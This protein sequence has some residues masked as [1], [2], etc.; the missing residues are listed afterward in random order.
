MNTITSTL[1][2]QTGIATNP[3]ETPQIGAEFNNFLQLLTAQLRNQDPLSPADSTQFVEQLATFSSLEQQVKSNTSLETIATMMGDLHAIVASEWLG[4]SVSV[5]SAWV[6]F[7]GKPVEFT[8]DIPQDVDN[9]IL[10]IRDNAGA[11]VWSS[12]LDPSAISHSW[13]GRN[14]RNDAQPQGV[15]QFGVDL[16]RGDAFAGTLAPRIITTVTDIANENG[17]LKFGT[18]SNLTTDLENVRKVEE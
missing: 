6:P 17:V 11:E 13:S 15:Y 5:E 7:D 3:T 18:A 1:P 16:Y 8:A 14:Q 2:L 9:A 10:T 12:A 4:Q